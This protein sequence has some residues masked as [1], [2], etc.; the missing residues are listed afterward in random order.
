MSS[1]ENPID[2]TQEA[3]YR[4]SRH[5][6]TP[7]ADH[8]RHGQYDCA[9]CLTRHAGGVF[10]DFGNCRHSCCVTCMSVLM[11]TSHQ[12]LIVRCP[13]CRAPGDFSVIC[14]TGHHASET[15][16]MHASRLS[17][18]I[19]LTGDTVPP[20]APGT[21]PRRP[22]PARNNAPRRRRRPAYHDM[23][24]AQAPEYLSYTPGDSDDNLHQSWNDLPLNAP[25]EE[26]AQPDD[27]QFDV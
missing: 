2:L 17:S 27:L 12:P 3:P 24:D 22:R 10:A 25:Y 15:L 8:A 19:D 4:Y 7:G 11:L 16:R 21:P 6:E 18:T 5:G 23:D 26:D 9:I 1:Y 14:E 13:I 20:P